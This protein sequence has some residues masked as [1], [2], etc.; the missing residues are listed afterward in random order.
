MVEQEIREI[1]IRDLVLWSE[2]PRDPIG[3][4]SSEQEIADAALG[5]HSSKWNLSRLATEMGKLFDYSEIPTVVFHGKKPIVYDGN[6]RVILA[7]IYHGLIDSNGLIDIARLPNFPNQI[8]CNVCQKN[9][10]LQ[11]IY[12][13]H[14]DSGSWQPLERDIFLSTHMRRPKSAFQLLDEETGL[15][16]KHKFLNQRFV[17]EEI[18]DEDTLQKLGI[19]FCDGYVRSKH[20]KEET[21]EIIRDI[22]E[23]VEAKVITTRKNRGEVISVLAPENRKHISEHAKNKATKIRLIESEIDSPSLSKVSD[24]STSS[25]RRT[26]RKRKS[27]PEVFG[28][29]LI[30]KTGEVGNMYRDIVDLNLFYQANKGSLSD[31]FPSMIRMSLRLICEIAARD[32]NQTLDVYI[33]SRFNAAKAQLDQDKQTLISNHN[34]K[35]GSIIQLLHTGAHSYTSSSN[36]EQTLALSLVVGKILESSH[37]K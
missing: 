3:Q 6:R 36:I 26:V 10:A 16:S 4:S 23:K 25:D 19:E 7:K 32:E 5:I 18:F 20:S 22:V 2:N 13:K 15:I 33:K 17:K 21:A 31:L 14:A 35:D 11:N 1:D 12:R 28:S 24:E 27:L 34:V 8:P 37:G 30:L 9:V 29:R